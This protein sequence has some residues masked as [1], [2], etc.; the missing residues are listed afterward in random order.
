MKTAF[1][2][3]VEQQKQAHI[4][5]LNEEKKARLA[6]LKDEGEMDVAKIKEGIKKVESMDLT[7]VK[8]KEL[9][10]LNTTGAFMDDNLGG[11]TK[12]KVPTAETHNKTQ[13]TNMTPNNRLKLK[14]LL[15]EGTRS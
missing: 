13:S 15:F 10:T 7:K 6:L 5:K 4:A 11:I 12:A 2:L 1:K 3:K 14:K 9:E 8:L